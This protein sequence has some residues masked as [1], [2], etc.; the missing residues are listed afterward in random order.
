M[1]VFE[2]FAPSPT[3]C[4]VPHVEL[5]HSMWFDAVNTRGGLLGRPVQPVI[6]QIG[7]SSVADEVEMEQAARQLIAEHVDFVIWPIGRER[8]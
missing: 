6:A 2:C 5:L 3:A 7:A 4:F 8:M 1:G